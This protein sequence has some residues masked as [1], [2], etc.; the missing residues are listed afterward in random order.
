MVEVA[1]LHEVV[2]HVVED[3]EEVVTDQPRVAESDF[4]HL[5][6]SKIL[7]SN[8]YYRAVENNYNNEDY[9]RRVY[10][11]Y[12]FKYLETRKCDACLIYQ[13]IGNTTTCVNIPPLCLFD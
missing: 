7:I 2:T 10:Y 9:N 6:A 1:E 13:L 11:Y 4:R 3:R 5:F 12:L 8:Y